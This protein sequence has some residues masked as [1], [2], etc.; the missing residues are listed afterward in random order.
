MATRTRGILVDSTL[1]KM[2]T[3]TTSVQSADSSKLIAGTKLQSTTI[4]SPRKRNIVIAKHLGNSGRGKVFPTGALLTKLSA[5]VL[6]APTGSSI[7]I[8]VKVGET[9][10]T[11]TSISILT[12][13]ELT[14]S[15]TNDVSVSIPANHALFLDVNQVGSIKPGQ[16]LGVTF[17][18]YA[19]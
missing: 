13:Q 12:I 16:S 5:S 9:Y 1:G 3:N 2:F 11:S 18:Y 6:I 19:G 15:T 4:Y 14:T 17:S 10:E 7:V 8:D